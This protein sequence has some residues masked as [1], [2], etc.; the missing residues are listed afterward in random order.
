MFITEIDSIYESVPF[1]KAGSSF[2]YFFGAC[3]GLSI[4][5]TYLLSFDLKGG[6]NRWITVLVVTFAIASCLVPIWVENF[7]A[8]VGISIALIFL[9]SLVAVFANEV[10]HIN[11]NYC[12]FDFLLL[13][14]NLNIYGIPS[15]YLFSKTHLE[16]YFD[17]TFAALILKLVEVDSCS[18][19]NLFVISFSVLAMYQVFDSLALIL[20]R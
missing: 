9:S 15:S 4:I 17:V 10:K 1:D 14:E 8:L 7:D 20:S 5:S 16:T 19:E 11:H 12:D 6:E 3:V 13:Q 2:T 18:M